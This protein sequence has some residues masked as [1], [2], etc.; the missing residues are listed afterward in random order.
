ML[1]GTS[2]GILEQTSDIP[3]VQLVQTSSIDRHAE[4]AG[5]DQAVAMV[6]ILLHFKKG[7]RLGLVSLH[8]NMLRSST[9]STNK[10]SD[11]MSLG[12][13]RSYDLLCCPE[14]LSQVVGG[15]IWVLESIRAFKIRRGLGPQLSGEHETGTPPLIDLSRS[16][17]LAR[18]WGLCHAKIFQV[19]P[20]LNAMQRSA[21]V[22]FAQAEFVSAGR[23][24][25]V[26]ITGLLGVLFGPQGRLCELALRGLEGSKVKC[27]CSLHPGVFTILTPPTP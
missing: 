23:G 26:A 11:R 15:L 6:C 10:H 22:C 24:R 21:L 13:Q 27:F 5:L 2:S 9:A 17:T 20:H 16:M 8:R 1:P 3:T 7:R 4:H 18:L 14:L 12:K 19:S 25:H